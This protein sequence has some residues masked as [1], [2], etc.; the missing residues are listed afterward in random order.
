MSP[1]RKPRAKKSAKRAT[2][3]ARKRAAKKAVKKTVRKAAKRT[4]AKKVA[5][6]TAK[7]V[8]KRPAAKGPAKRAAAKRPA[9]RPALRLVK[10]AAKRAPAKKPFAG[11]IAGA[12]L[13]DLALFDLVRARVEVQAAIQGMTAGS[14]EQAIAPGKW[15]SRQIV[16]HLHVWD[17]D[18]LPWVEKAYR[19]GV[20]PPW[21]KDDILAHNHE[22]EDELKAHEWE[23]AR[24]LM[25]QS[26]E[27][28]LETLQSLPEE[29]AEMW[30]GEHALG[31]LIRILAH[32]DRHHAAKLKEARSGPPGGA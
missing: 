14:A 6:R 32:H 10:P 29:P 1:T 30:A 16:L 5:K 27:I 15:N 13:K 7:P 12:S 2:K 17:R 21:S 22:S 26:R 18:I 20:R 23:Q 8:A 24:R 31:W 19:Q 3:P 9:K 25:Q 4:A 28:L 11:A